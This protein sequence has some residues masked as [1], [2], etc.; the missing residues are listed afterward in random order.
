[1]SLNHKDPKVFSSN[2]RVS[3]ST[4][5][6]PTDIEQVEQALK[7]R[8][9]ELIRWWI[10]NFGVVDIERPIK[11]R[12]HLLLLGL[13]HGSTID[14]DIAAF[15]S[16]NP[17]RPPDYLV[18]AHEFDGAI[19]HVYALDSNGAVL[20]NSGFL[21]PSSTYTDKYAN[22]RWE[23]AFLNIEEFWDSKVQSYLKQ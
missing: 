14:D 4:P 16:S 23:P 22:S 19:D 21:F 2:P 7:L 12:P 15:N 1:M 20:R 5:L 17:T 11:G 10:T 3:P 9:P 18:F 6:P 13:S 8:F